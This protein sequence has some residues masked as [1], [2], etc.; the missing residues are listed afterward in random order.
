MLRLLNLLLQWKV[1][2]NV[3]KSLDDAERGVKEEAHEE[4]SNVL[5]ACS[6]AC[7]NLESIDL[8]IFQLH[9]HL[10]DPTAVGTDHKQT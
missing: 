9:N 2:Y 6:D 4:Y 1:E 3:S 5:A 8:G 7:K 10:L